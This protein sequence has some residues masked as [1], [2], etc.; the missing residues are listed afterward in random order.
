MI[1]RA[2]NFMTN[3]RDEK[4]KLPPLE[5]YDLW[6]ERLGVHTYTV[7]S[8]YAGLLAASNLAKMLGEYESASKWE[9]TAWRFERQLGTTYS[10]GRGACFI[11]LSGLMMVR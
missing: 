9:E 10:I 3:F 7:A 4:L 2:A 6:E 1:T 8:V 11:G 5:S